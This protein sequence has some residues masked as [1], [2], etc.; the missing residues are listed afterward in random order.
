MP[1]YKISATAHNGRDPI[2]PL[3]PQTIDAP[4]AIDAAGQLAAAHPQP[5]GWTLTVSAR[6]ESPAFYEFESYDFQGAGFC[7]PDLSL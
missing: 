2:R 7:I 5:E 6:A 4:S 3:P 1:T